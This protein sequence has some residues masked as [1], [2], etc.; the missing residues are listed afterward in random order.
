MFNPSA[1]WDQFSAPPPPWDTI[2]L[3]KYLVWIIL[4]NLQTLLSLFDCI[5]AASEVET[6]CAVAPVDKKTTCKSWYCPTMW[7]PGNWTEVI[8]FGGGLFY[9]LHHLPVPPLPTAFLGFIFKWILIKTIIRPFLKLRMYYHSPQ[10]KMF[11]WLSSILYK[12]KRVQN[13]L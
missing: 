11:Q 10:A 12:N 13:S 1:K 4:I 5:C 3:Q 9:P 7:L 8:S 6:M 2:S